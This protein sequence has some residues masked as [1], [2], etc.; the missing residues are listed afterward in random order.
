MNDFLDRRFCLCTCVFLIVFSV[1]YILKDVLIKMWLDE[2]FTLY[3]AQQHTVLDIVKATKDGLDNAPPLY[4]II[5]SWILPVIRHDALALRLPST[6]GYAGMLLFILAFCRHRIPAPYC[7][8]AALLACIACNYYASEGR[9]YGMVLF[10]VAAALFYW[11][12]AV[13][14]TKRV[15]PI[16]LLAICLML[17]TALHY[18]SIF[19]LIPI[20]AAEMVRIRTTRKLDIAIICALASPFAV[21]VIHYP[22]IAAGRKDLLHFWPDS[23]ASWYQIT[24]FYLRLFSWL[25]ISV[26]LV[27]FLAYSVVSDQRL[28]P[29]DWE[30]RLPIYEWV[31]IILTALAPF[32]IVG[33]AKYATHV[34]LK[35]YALWAVIGL[36]VLTATLLY[37]TTSAEPVVS[38][39]VLLLLLC[40]LVGQ[41]Y[42]DFRH[43][44]RL[45]ESE[46]VQQALQRL[47]DGS[48]PIVIGYERVFAELS[49]YGDPRVRERIVYPI[50]QHLELRYRGSD[51]NFFQMLA[52]SRWT[53]LRIVDLDQFLR[54]NPRFVLATGHRE[55]L[56][57][58]LTSSGYR[59]T[60]IDTGSTPV[61][62]EVEA[63]GS[64]R[65]R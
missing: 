54:R 6:L 35:R 59:L 28:P 29:G 23:I 18:Y 62:Y 1:C 24:A 8:T 38:V 2:F 3:L 41:N 37:I 16:T 11:Q 25:P 14:T 56:S 51:V 7:F 60:P 48:E 13:N 61:L 64:A 52:L 12:T 21:L 43:I 31:A 4:A 47:P 30:R 49:Y 19:F 10:F 5:V 50:S 34:F 45:R 46:A 57:T 42:V 27:A 53:N 32:F 58:Y 22:L 39:T 65:E 26:F 63:P 44:R 17:M 40:V 33:I 36:A 55:Y 20:G 15:L 9:C